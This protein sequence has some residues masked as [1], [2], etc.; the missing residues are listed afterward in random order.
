[1]NRRR[2]LVASLAAALA[3]PLGAASQQDGRLPRVGYLTSESR[4]VDVESFE[5]GLRD[6]GYTPGQDILIDYRFADWRVEKIPSLVAELLR[7]RP[8]VFLAASPYVIRAATH[9]PKTM[10]IVGIDLE[11]DPQKAG[12][13]KSIAKPGANLTGFFLDIPELSGKQVQLLAETVVRLRRVAV[14]WDADAATLQ[15]DAIKAAAQAQRRSGLSLA[16][17]Q[18]SEYPG[19]LSSAA[20]QPAEAIVVLSSP[21]VF[22]NLK[23]LAELALQHHLPSISVFPQF[24]EVGGLIGYGPVLPDLFRRSARYVDRILK[25][26]TPAEL[27]IQRPTI[28]RLIINLKTAR[29]L[30]VTIPPSLLARAD[31]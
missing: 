26:A 11:T 30:G 28:F 18:P 29:A 4:S 17:R 23:A 1:M 8:D 7:L 5:L 22:M 19:A 15:F 24:A 13:I 10:P 20:R 6:L 31:R 27:P 3:V 12:W 25:G 14:L 9:A 2:F 16:F 21:A